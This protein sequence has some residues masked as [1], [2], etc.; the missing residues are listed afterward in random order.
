MAINETATGANS[1]AVTGTA[2]GESTIGILGKGDAVGVQGDGKNWHGVAGLSESTIGGNG[3]F[4][5]NK[6]GTG[7]RGESETKF[8]AGV[9]GL[10]KGEAGWGVRGEADN[11]A[12]TVGVSKNWHGV[13]GE[14]NSTTGGV[15]VHGKH[16]SNGAGVS[17]ESQTGVGIF[18]KGGRLAGLF[19]GNV[20]ITGNLTI[21]GVSIQALIQ[22]IQQLEQQVAS[23]SSGSGGTVQQAFVSCGLEDDGSFDFKLL[24]IRG[25][26]FKPGEEVSLKITRKIEGQN[27][28][29]E[30]RQTTADSFGSI[31]F[32]YGSGFCG[33][34][35]PQH[36]TFQVQGTGLTSNKVSNVATAGC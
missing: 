35:P 6:N 13:Y 10:H 29:T 9:L 17:G 12:G 8:N 32:K 11:G 15:G 23:L 28:S 14:T 21:Q 3:V 26:S 22:R 2:T 18:A 34:F 4:G 16:L 24:R 7:V 5:A 31:D 19:E 20:E 1:I 25:N 33:G 30:I 27:P 36:S